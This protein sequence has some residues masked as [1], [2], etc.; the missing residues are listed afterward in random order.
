[1][2][3]SRMGRALASVALLSVS[4]L[5]AWDAEGHRITA[6]EAVALLEG[7]LPEFVQ[8]RRTE[9]SRDSLDPDLMRIP[10]LPQLRDRESPHHYLN[11]ERLPTGKLPGTRSAFLQLI[12]T[13]A[14]NTTIDQIGA[15]V[16]SVAE[17]TQSLT[18]AFAQVRQQPANEHLQ[19]KAIIFAGHLAHYA[20]D[21]CQPLHT[22][23]HH[24]GRAL[25]NF[26]SPQTG[27][28]Q[29]VDSLIGRLR[30]QDEVDLDPPA[31]KVATALFQTVLDEL[32]RSHEEVERVYRLEV[33]LAA[34]EAGGEPSGELQ[35]LTR[36]R[37]RAATVFAA[38][39]ILTAWRDS[40][41]LL[42]PDWGLPGPTEDD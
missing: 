15:L 41:Q 4:P 35:S 29:Q 18:L 13:Q 5:L 17:A 34:L 40:A 22:T 2:T 20:S 25:E 11:L 37:Y 42:L 6:S 23:V 12:A 39:L 10:T 3:G 31:A 28:H 14:P 36:D 16:Y 21:L 8:E 19:A 24:D 9:L 1:M 38:S 30:P 7:E 27:I 26:E 33:D 32:R